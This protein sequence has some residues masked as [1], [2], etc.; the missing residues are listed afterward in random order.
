M[1]TSRK[2]L[3]TLQVKGENGPQGPAT[4]N[5]YDSSD[6]LA[7]CKFEWLE[8]N[9]MSFNNFMDMG[10]L[11][12]TITHVVAGF[13]TYGES[14]FGRT[15]NIAVAVKHGNPCGASWGEAEPSTIIHAMLSGDPISVF[16]GSVMVN[17]HIGEHEAQFLKKT[18]LDTIFAPSIDMV[19]REMLSRKSGKCRIVCNANLAHLSKDSLDPTMRTSY[20][21]GGDLTQQNYTFVMDMNHPEMKRHGVSKTATRTQEMNMLLAWAIGSTSNSNTITL[22]RNQMLIGNGAGQQ[23]RVGAAQLAITRALR[24]KHK[25]EGAVAYSDSFFPFSDGPKALIDAGVK[26]I[27]TTSGSMRD[28]ETI[29]LCVQHGVALY[30]MPDGLARGFYAHC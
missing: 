12:Q 1:S 30:M 3:H 28:Q 2:I 17:F 16:G 9:L 11:L 7:L 8:G 29:D 15:R 5:V 23:D 6:P 4:L 20:L 21:R 13:E 10:R 19:A 24:S 14:G 27:L 26:A 22:V 25:I 18:T